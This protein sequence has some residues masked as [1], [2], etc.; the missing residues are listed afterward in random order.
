MRPPNWFVRF[1]DIPAPERSGTR[2]T[3]STITLSMKKS[4]ADELRAACPETPTNANCTSPS[5]APR[6]IVTV[7]PVFEIVDELLYVASVF[8]TSQVAPPSEDISTRY[9]SPARIDV[10]PVPALVVSAMSNRRRNCVPVPMSKIGVR[11]HSHM[12]LFTSAS[13]AAPVVPTLA[14]PSACHAPRTVPPDG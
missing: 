5:S 4:G 3:G 12:L 7:C 2:G 6:L 1:A 9:E 8:A 14:K 13:R 11:S 10:E